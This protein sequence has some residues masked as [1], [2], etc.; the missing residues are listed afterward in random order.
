MTNRDTQTEM[1]VRRVLAE[2]RKAAPEP[3]PYLKTRVLAELRSRQQESRLRIWKLFA[4][5][6]G[7]FSV[8]IVASLFLMAGPS[9]NGSYVAKVDDHVLIRVEVEKLQGQGVR[10]AEVELPQGTVLRVRV[11]APLTIQ[12]GR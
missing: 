9:T 8:L 3:S 10:F 7:A 6:S 11:D 4:M 2:A 5:T 1:N 12:N